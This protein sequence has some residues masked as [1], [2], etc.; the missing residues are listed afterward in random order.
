MLS[1]AT[2]SISAC[3]MEKPWLNPISLLVSLTSRKRYNARWTPSLCT[4][5]LRVQ[6][7]ASPRT[8]CMEFHWRWHWCLGFHGTSSGANASAITISMIRLY[9]WTIE[10]H[11]DFVGA[12]SWQ[13]CTCLGHPKEHCV[14]ITFYSSLVILTIVFAAISMLCSEG[15]AT[16]CFLRGLYIP[17]VFVPESW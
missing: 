14:R 4:E 3:L 1:C 7:A 12:N 11:L 2:R 17:M 16:S 8:C 5:W 13:C 6:I 15:T 9:R 10:R